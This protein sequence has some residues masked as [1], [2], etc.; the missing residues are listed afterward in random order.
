[1]CWQEQPGAVPLTCASRQGRLILG[2]SPAKNVN[3]GLGRKPL[4]LKEP[5]SQLYLQQPP[6][7]LVPHG[8]QLWLQ[9]LWVFD[10]LGYPEWG[11]GAL[12]S[13]GPLLTSWGTQSVTWWPRKQWAKQAVQL[14][15]HHNLGSVG[16]YTI[17]CSPRQQHWLLGRTWK[18][19]FWESCS[20]RQELCEGAIH[21]HG[22]QPIHG[23][24]QTP[25]MWLSQDT[26]KVSAQTSTSIPL[27]LYPKH[28]KRHRPNFITGFSAIC[29]TQ[30]G[31]ANEHE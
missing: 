4:I 15:T 24:C 18:E 30:L 28:P 6:H 16:L 8:F 7:V 14:V 12:D 22:N 13:S 20:W 25:F 11:S 2:Y 10:V 5:W 26:T 29:N 31:S 9:M 21:W 1:M 3:L 17:S 23:G 19:A 27:C